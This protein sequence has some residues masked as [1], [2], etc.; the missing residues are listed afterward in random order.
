MTNLVWIGPL[1]LENNLF[2]YISPIFFS[3]F[4]DYFPLEKH[5]A[6]PSN[7]LKSSQSKDALCQVC[8]QLASWFRIIFFLKLRQ[9]INYLPLKKGVALYFFKL[10]SPSPMDVLSK[11]V[12][13]DPVVPEKK[14]KM[15]KVYD[16]DDDNDEDDNDAGQRTNFDQKSS[17]EPSAQVS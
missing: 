8:L 16:N 10:E 5:M 6:L 7:K 12:E 4:R 14:I 11:L 2:S 1:V 9:C 3:Q 13:I 17:L 15:W